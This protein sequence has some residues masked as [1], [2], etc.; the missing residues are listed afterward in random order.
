MIM[1]DSIDHIRTHT[2]FIAFVRTLAADYS[3]QG[4]E[5][6]NPTIDRFLEA[7]AA[8]LAD[9]PPP[10]VDPSGSPHEI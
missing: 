5:W 3:V 8:W 7:F 9:M 2:E 10:Q 1:A 6:E 4:E